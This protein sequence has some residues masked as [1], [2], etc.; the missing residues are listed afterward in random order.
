[1]KLDFST[2]SFARSAP[3]STPSSAGSSRRQEPTRPRLSTL[4]A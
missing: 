4:I 3:A 1:M 2:T